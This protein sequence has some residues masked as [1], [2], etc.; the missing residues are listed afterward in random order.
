VGEF[1]EAFRSRI[2]ICLFYPKL[3]KSSTD[4][5]WEKNIARIKSSG[6]DITVEEDEIRRF[7]ELLWKENEKN[8][9]RHW[10]GRQIKNAF[11][12]SI[13]LAHWDFEECADND[14]PSRPILSV[15]H[16]KR[17]GQTSAHFDDYIGNIY[18]IEAQDVY[19]VLAAREEFRKDT[20]PNLPFMGSKDRKIIPRTRKIKGPRRN[21]NFESTDTSD[22]DDEDSDEEKIEEGEDIEKLK[23][24]LEIAKLK[25][26]YAKGLRKG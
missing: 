5:I 18:G 7:Y 24:R 9:T 16:F 17:V 13:A 20:V 11:Q 10:N 4:K 3:D 6:A 26:R 19:S 8:P 21:S 14:R 2:H 12:T 1:D 25:E 23:L 15:K 22:S